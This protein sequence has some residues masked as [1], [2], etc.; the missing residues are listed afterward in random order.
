MKQV[1][2]EAKGY[3]NGEE[4]V[5]SEL[6]TMQLPKGELT[7]SHL[8]TLIVDAEALLAE[9]F[10]VM[11]GC[12]SAL[13]NASDN[14]VITVMMRVVFND[15]HA[16]RSYV[17]AGAAI[18][19]DRGILRVVEFNDNTQPKST[20][21]SLLAGL[22]AEYEFTMTQA[23]IEEAFNEAQDA[24]ESAVD[25]TA[26]AEE[27][28]K[29]EDIM[30]EQKQPEEQLVTVNIQGNDVQMTVEALMAIQHVLNTTGARIIGNAMPVDNTK[31][32]K[33]EEKDL[34]EYIKDIA[35][36]KG[37]MNEEAGMPTEITKA[38][39]YAE[40]VAQKA[41]EMMDAGRTAEYILDSFEAWAQEEKTMPEYKT[42]LMNYVN[43]VRN[44]ITPQPKKEMKQW[45]KEAIEKLT[46]Y[47]KQDLIG[48][49]TLKKLASKDEKEKAE[50]EKFVGQLQS[51]NGDS[52]WN[53]MKG[54]VVSIKGWTITATGRVAD[55][56][57][58]LGEYG[59]SMTEG[60]FNLAGDALIAAGNML[61]G[62]APTAGKVVSTPINMVGDAIN[63]LNG[64][65]KTATGNKEQKVDVMALIKKNEQLLR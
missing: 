3:I 20:C 19:E 41:K 37:I 1:A 38:D 34:P 5:L 55:T 15:M 48:I 44:T 47:D 16:T 18:L 61:K 7:T 53:S 13:E 6:Y 56:I 45:L 24:D 60:A 39:P 21:P 62:A 12:H 43:E 33:V 29:E 28:N 14:D 64:T 40:W 57:Y 10:K 51:E 30:E 54:H 8:T 17:L 58:L 27:N 63:I 31:T 46:S 42:A 32:T 35:K 59:G 36:E 52:I 22:K 11:I 26:A 49:L 23:E 4:K 65:K 9:M 25:E 50:I 2:M